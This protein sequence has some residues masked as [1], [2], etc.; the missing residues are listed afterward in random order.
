ME[1]ANTGS[2]SQR[3]KGAS[4]VSSRFLESGLL[5]RGPGGGCGSGPC[6]RTGWQRCPHLLRAQRRPK[7]PL[8][9]HCVPSVFPLD[10]AVKTSLAV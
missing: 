5:V 9:A 10:T 8:P 2:C 3:S 4:P 6:R 7:P 1:A